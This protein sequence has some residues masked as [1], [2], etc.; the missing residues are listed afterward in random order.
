LISL[1]CSFIVSHM[2]EKEE[3]LTQISGLCVQFWVHDFVRFYSRCICLIV[4]VSQERKTK[5]KNGDHAI[6][7]VFLY[8]IPYFYFVCVCLCCL[9]ERNWKCW[10]KIYVFVFIW[11]MIPICLLYGWHV[12]LCCKQNGKGK[13][14]YCYILLF[15]LVRH[16]CR[17]LTWFGWFFLGMLL[18]PFAVD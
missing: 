11:Y 7:F 16:T 5:L 17:I 2:Y 18:V 8:M 13:M 9:L 10:R 6:L 14:C 4:F 1:I 15:G 3:Y 12:M